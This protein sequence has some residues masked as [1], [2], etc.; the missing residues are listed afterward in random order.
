MRRELRTL[1][2]SAFQSHL[3]NLF[4]A[5]VIE[6][7]TRREQRVMV[8]LKAGLFPFAR[9]LEPEGAARLRDWP[10]PLPSSRN[11]LPEG[12]R[13]QIIAEVLADYQLTWPELR[14]RHLKDV[15][16]SKG[17]R[18]A[19]VFP[20]KLV[21]TVGDDEKH[22]GRSVLRLGF[23]LGKGSYATIMVK[24]ISAGAGLS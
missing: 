4:L 20:E 17:S 7:S 11:V 13:G 8:A 1:Y 19:L 5:R 22:P 21:A 24:R 10:I 6:Q 2:F 15:F 3:W 14:V 18:P 12:P 9:G 23:E 16:F